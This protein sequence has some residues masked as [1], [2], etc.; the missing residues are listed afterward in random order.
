MCA[1]CMLCHM[2]TRVQVIKKTSLS[3]EDEQALQSEVDILQR[4]KHPNIVQVSGTLFVRRMYTKFH[5]VLY[6][7]HY[8]NTV[9][10]QCIDVPTA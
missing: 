3:P 4:V 8:N 7:I 10:K 1:H 9:C 5:T 2:S 6:N